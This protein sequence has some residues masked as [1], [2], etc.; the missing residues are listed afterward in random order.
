M[1]GILEKL[2]LGS[3]IHKFAEEK[4]TP[5]I[6]CRLSA[7]DLEVLGL[8]GRADM[9]RLRAECIKFGGE[10]LPKVSS[11]CG[12]PKFEIPKS[13]LE[14][15]L[16]EGFSINEISTLLSISE[17]TVYRRMR[18]FGLSKLAFSEISDD[19]LDRAVNHICQDFPRCGENMLK[20]ILSG[21]GIKVQRVRLRDS[22]HRVDS[23]GVE[24]RK[25]GRLHRRVYNVQCPNALWHVD[26]NHKLVRWNFVIFGCVDGF[27]RL[28]VALKCLNN[29]KANTLLQCFTDGVQ[30]YGL[31]SR[32]RSD[33]GL[34]NVHI[35]QFMIEK[36]G[37]ERGSI[38]TGKSTHNQR[39]ERLWRD[40][41]NGVL[42]FYYNLFYFMEE[43]TLLDPLNDHHI[44]ALH[45]VYFPKINEKLETWRNAWARHRIRTTRSSPMQMWLS[46]QIQNPVG[47][48]NIN[49]ADITMYGVEGN[50]TEEDGNGNQ[51]PIFDP[52]EVELSENC[53]QEMAHQVPS[54]WTSDNY[55]IDK[56]EETL[57][58]IYNHIHM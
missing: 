25:R 34:E 16:D 43:S 41:F 55:G 38:I 3:C 26:T 19:D 18:T 36:R 32:V 4:I 46:G 57:G 51:R 37:R 13:V 44:A 9:M 7:Y 35:A 53:L 58:I 28:C 52:P 23:E 33:N 56:F 42:C 48:D 50:I 45:H 6:V 24:G 40:V 8:H 29:N 2:N 31:P 27:S 10:Q 17:S 14:N 39:V 5:D 30:A 12:A 11:C 54:T 21:K 22:I 47:V 49:M 15:L 20:Q 1:E